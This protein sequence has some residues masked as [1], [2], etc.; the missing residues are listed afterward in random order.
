ML[1]LIIY[2]IPLCEDNDHVEGIF[3]TGPRA[4]YMVLAWATWCPRAA[5]WWPLV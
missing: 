1:L 2:D 3:K 5:C 4:T